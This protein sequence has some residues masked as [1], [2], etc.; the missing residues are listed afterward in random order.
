MNVMYKDLIGGQKPSAPAKPTEPQKPTVVTK[1]IPSITYAVK[2]ASATLSDVNDGRETGNGQKIVGIK[3]GVDYGT[4]RY[5]V[6]CGGRWLPSV[7]G[8]NWKDYDNGYAG[9]D[10]NAIDA[11]QIYYT[12]DSTKTE[13]YQAVYCVQP[14]GGSYLPEVY[15]TNWEST[16]GNYTA[17]LFNKPFGRIKIKLVRY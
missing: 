2:T 7:M 9:D 11:I 8:N 13:I 4:V 5:R 12:S 1:P 17:G 15:D 6:H 14:I 16:D 3:I 10:K